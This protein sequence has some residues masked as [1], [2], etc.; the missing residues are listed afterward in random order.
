MSKRTYLRAL[1]TGA[2]ILAPVTPALAQPSAADDSNII[3]VTAQNRAQAVNDVPIAIDVVT[4]EK[5]QQAGFSNMNDI[6]K[7]APAVQ[8]NQDQGTVK[9]TV[10]GVGTNSNDEAQD[11]S[12]VINIDGEYL[13][14]PNALGVS[15][16]DLDRVEVL[17][18][19]Q[20]TLY[21]RNSTGGAINFITRKPGT[22]FGANASASYGNY[23]AVRVDGGIDLPFGTIGGLRLAGF[24]DEHDGYTRHPA[25]PGFFVFP[26]FAGGRSDDNQAYGGRVSLQLEP[27][28]H[29]TINVAG[30]YAER[31]FI[32]S[33]FAYTDLNG[34]G[35]G[36]GP[37]C[38]LNGYSRVAPAYPQ[39]L[40]VPSNTNFLSTIDRSNFPTPFFGLGNIDQKTYAFRGRVAYEFSEA[41]T[42]TYTG[43]YRNFKE[44]SYRP[45]P[46]VYQSFGFGNE[47]KT[48]SHELRLNGVVGGITYQ[49]GGFYFKE[50]IA[51]E[52]GFFVAPIGLPGGSF[53]TY[54]GR[55]IS[56]DSKSVF[57]QVEVPLGSTLTAVGGLRYTKNSRDATYIQGNPFTAYN[58]V[59]IPAGPGCSGA[60]GSCIVGS[61]NFALLG[62]GP[63]R[64]DVFNIA[65]NIQPLSTSEDKITWLA[66]L[67]YK[68]NPNTLIYGKVAT[69][70]KGGG[71][72]AIG[73]YKPE[74]NTAY[75]GGWKQ[76]FG[77][78][79]QHQ[80]NLSAF[81]YDYKDLQV[82]VLLDTTK[83]GQTFN[84]GKAKIYGFEATADIALDDNDRFNASF[85][86]LHAK[87]GELFAQFNVFTVPGTGPDIN[88]VGD[89]DP[90]TPG[91]QQPNFKG[92]TPPFSPKFIITMGYEHVF[93]LGGAGHLT[94][95][96]DTLFKS[97]YFTD[98]YN[99][100]DGRQSAYTQT[101]ASLEY[102]PENRRFTVAV[103]ARNLENERTL[104]Y[105]SFVSAG[106]DDIYNWQFG[107]PRTYG[108]RVGVDF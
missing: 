102:K 62:T 57:G 77:D 70:F 13:N 82:S 81:Y 104:T 51:S 108:V 43:G 68:P 12:V 76:T 24:Y 95:R 47:T 29:L 40:C 35:N 98:F 2:A 27:I 17:R 61:P 4:G 63:A 46:I 59:A 107:T 42:L 58:T 74:S 75:E 55:F 39:T 90:N 73:N 34:A 44:N 94:A 32:P 16:F 1:L 15:L 41:A 91:I 3:I 86:Y 79:R 105:G 48:Q 49:L 7:I 84:A 78:H 10:R 45:L 101:G 33:T 30:E 87:Y 21:G 37:N 65:A 88:G 83:G 22:E 56:S 14:R 25:R 99:Y 71:F 50:K 23:N 60:I 72:D 54:F 85:N 69:G 100:R 96:V 67:N 103:F 31:H 64:K 36:P 9:V 8:L 53:L 66:G 80:F 52:S 19:P 20:G 28:D 6:D 89:L 11:T 106:P 97:A 18:G 26:A 93:D 92:N 38:T 5:L